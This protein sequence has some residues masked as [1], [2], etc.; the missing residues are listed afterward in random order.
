MSERAVRFVCQGEQLVG[1]VSQP[2]SATA[3]LG[4]LIVVGGPQYRVGSHRQFVLLARRL[5]EAGYPVMR[6][7]LRGMGDSSGEPRD[8]SETGEDIAAALSAFQAVCPALSRVAVWGL[9][10]AAS[11]ALL[12]WQAERDPRLAGLALLNPWV[13]SEQ[14]LARTH[15]RHYYRERLFQREFWQKLLSGRLQVGRSV[16]EALGKLRLMR[17]SAKSGSFQERMA[18]ALREFP[19]AMLLI[20][21]GGDLTAKEFADWAAERFGPGWEKMPRLACHWLEAAD[22][23]FSRSEWRNWVELL[24]LAWLEQLGKAP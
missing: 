15:V 10:D 17:G 7:D 5:A 12:Y 19:G 16:A 24:T 4:L 1:I 18:H 22:H 14:S 11:A 13:R 3:S 23:T 20:L 6:F 8:F 9:C 21:S 2:E